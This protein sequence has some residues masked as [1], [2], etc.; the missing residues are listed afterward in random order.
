MKF[1][2]LLPALCSIALA[3]PTDMAT[4]EERATAY[5]RDA[6]FHAGWFDGNGDCHVTLAN[7]VDTSIHCT[8]SAISGVSG[9]GGNDPPT[10]CAGWC[11][12]QYCY[13]ASCAGWQG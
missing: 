12:D 10:N 4:K 13:G 9:N 1:A 3:L 8:D 6:Y 7:Y 2:V 11:D 5:P